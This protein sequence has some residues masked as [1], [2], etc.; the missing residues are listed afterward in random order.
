MRANVAYGE[1]TLEPGAV[2][3]DLDKV[4]KSVEGN[5]EL[6]KRPA[7]QYEVP[8]SPPAA[9]VYDTAGESA[10]PSSEQQHIPKDT[11]M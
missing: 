10:K 2:Y 7:A 1:V 11:E 8:V 9:P 4:V 3:E 5:F 6:K